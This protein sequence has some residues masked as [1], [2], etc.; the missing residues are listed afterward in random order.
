PAPPPPNRFF[1][2]WTREFS[3]LT[4]YGISH[5]ERVNE[6]G[7]RNCEKWKKELLNYSPSVV[8]MLRQLKLAGVDVKSENLPCSPCDQTRTGGFLP[9]HGAIILCQANLLGNKDHLEHTMVHELVHMFDHVKFK[10][11]WNDLR[12][13]A[14]SEI[15]AA[16]LSGE[17]KWTREVDRRILNF[18]K[19]HQAS[20]PSACVRRRAI[21]AVM[22]NEACLD[23]TAAER[24]VNEVWESCFN[25]TRP[26]DEV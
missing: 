4:G 3:L 11:R 26:F 1:Q 15:R 22:A 17:C 25:D 9:D 7:R 8:F 14:C 18:S 12:H 20:L 19:Q 16:S 5:D 23:K 10:V 24:A 6:I 21:T 2:E 13:H